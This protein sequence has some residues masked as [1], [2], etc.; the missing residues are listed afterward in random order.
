MEKQKQRGHGFWRRGMAAVLVMSTVLLGPRC[1]AQVLTTV[2][3]AGPADCVY[4]AGNPDLYPIEYYDSEQQC[5][6]GILPELLGMVAEDTG[7]SFA[8]VNAGSEDSRLEMARNSQVEMVTAFR[9]GEFSRMV[10]P[11]QRTVLTTETDGRET[12][13][14]VGFTGIIKEELRERIIK[15]LEAIPEED[16]TTLAISFTL[17]QER[18]PGGRRHAW[19]GRRLWQ[20][21]QL[22]C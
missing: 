20:R 21:R 13:I 15:A 22:H 1:A 3:E 12:A 8:Y 19:Q 11:V 14:C 10:L 7:I 18:R 9:R 6:R 2:E 5:Y 17:G 16:K 4:I